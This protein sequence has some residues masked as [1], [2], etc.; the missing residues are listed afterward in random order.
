MSDAVNTNIVSLGIN[1]HNQK[2]MSGNNVIKA[3]QHL[4]DDKSSGEENRYSDHIIHTYYMCFYLY[5][6]MLC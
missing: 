4:K 6:L 2:S 5:Y 3:L 1:H